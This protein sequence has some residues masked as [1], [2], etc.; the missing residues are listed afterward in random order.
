VLHLPASRTKQLT[1]RKK[2]N[3]I[4]VSFSFLCPVQPACFLC[5]V[6]RLVRLRPKYVHALLLTTTRTTLHEHAHAR[7]RNGHPRHLLTYISCVQPGW[8][9]RCISAYCCY[10]SCMLGLLITFSAA[11]KTE[12]PPA[13]SPAGICQ[14]SCFV[15]FFLGLIA[16]L[17]PHNTHTHTHT[18]T[19]FLWHRKCERGRDNSQ[20]CLIFFFFF[21]LPP[22]GF[23]SVHT[24]PAWHTRLPQHQEKPQ[25]TESVSPV[26]LYFF[27]KK[28]W[29]ASG[30]GIARALV[31]IYC[32]TGSLSSC[33]HSP[34]C[35]PWPARPTRCA[36]C[37]SSHFSPFV[38]PRALLR[39]VPRFTQPSCC[40]PQTDPFRSGIA[41]S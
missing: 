40:I 32:P 33:P 39:I 35:E 36:I 23:L 13:A 10:F 31:R 6:S 5:L 21:S 28:E 27:A 1:A 9:F 38:S 19:H 3:T 16:P 41:M 26:C 12:L 11:T 7:F 25:Q 8:D 15:V 17:L 14:A 24:R 4:P 37:P 22:P 2:G 34:A 29:A 30:L 18:H 20:L